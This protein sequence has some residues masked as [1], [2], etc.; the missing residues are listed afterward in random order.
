MHLRPR[1]RRR[2]PSGGAGGLGI[3]WSRGVDDPAA[4]EVRDRHAWQMAGTAREGVMR[5]IIGGMVAAAAAAG[6]IALLLAQVCVPACAEGAPCISDC[7]VNSP[8][9]VPAVILAVIAIGAI[10]LGLRAGLRRD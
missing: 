10:A 5:L 4:F 9:F 2:Q 3:E 8:W 1:V 6:W 7:G